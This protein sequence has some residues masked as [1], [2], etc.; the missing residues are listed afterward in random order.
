MRRDEA[1]AETPTDSVEPAHA[2]DAPAPREADAD[3]RVDAL[4]EL[5]VPSP[6]AVRAPQAPRLTP[7]LRTAELEGL[8]TGRRATIRLRG[9]LEGIP[10]TLAPEVDG[11]LVAGA[12]ESGQSALVEIDEE[13]EVWIVG[14]VQTRIPERLVLR[15]D[16]VVVQGDTEV[17]LQSGKAGMRLRED[18]DVELVGSR[19]MHMSRGLFRIVG[20]MLRLN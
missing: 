1:Q 10:A 18:G 5:T 3:A 12:L 14:V 7:G 2:L 6:E 20:R 4:V 16:T 9:R 8:L 15:A 13:G 19:I 17:L 11:E